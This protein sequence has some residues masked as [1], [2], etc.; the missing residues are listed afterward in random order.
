MVYR[1]EFAGVIVEVAKIVVHESGQRHV[2]VDPL[3][4]HLLTSETPG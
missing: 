2:V 1:F 4:T 3:D